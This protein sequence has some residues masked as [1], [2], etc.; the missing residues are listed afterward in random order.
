MFLRSMFCCSLE[1]SGSPLRRPGSS[2]SGG[3]GAADSPK[4]RPTAALVPADTPTVVVSIYKQ[5]IFISLV[6]LFLKINIT[7][8]YLKL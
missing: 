6:D 3:D 7:F 4:H 1:G 2:A 5:L 8:I